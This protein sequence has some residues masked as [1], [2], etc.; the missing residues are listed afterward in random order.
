MEVVHISYKTDRDSSIVMKRVRTQPKVA[1]S[2]ILL[3]I[4]HDKHIGTGSWAADGRDRLVAFWFSNLSRL[5]PPQW[6][7]WL[8]FI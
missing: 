6:P 4:I 8:P 7:S 3:Q 1:Q 2:K 5:S